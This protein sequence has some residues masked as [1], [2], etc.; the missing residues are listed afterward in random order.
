MASIRVDSSSS[1]ATANSSARPAPAGPTGMAP[2][3]G[4]A[5]S[6]ACWPK[7]GTGQ[8]RLLAA[9]GLACELPQLGEDRQLLQAI[10]APGRSVGNDDSLANGSVSSGRPS[11]KRCP[12][13][14]PSPGSGAGREDRHLRP[15]P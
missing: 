7:A 3:I 1:W 8:G 2:S 11:L 9:P 5:L 14:A 13:A 15:A 6:D 4:S 12:I 10:R